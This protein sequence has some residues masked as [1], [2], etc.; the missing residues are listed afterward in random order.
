MVLAGVMLV[1]QGIAQVLRCIHCIRHGSWY[2]MEEA[3]EV[4]ETEVLLMRQQQQS[5]EDE[6]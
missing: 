4:E 2:E 6:K 5:K 1:V 3:D